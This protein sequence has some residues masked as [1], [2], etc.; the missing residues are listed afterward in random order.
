MPSGLVHVAFL[1]ARLA[2][3]LTI[4]CARA[5]S[6]S[7]PR[8][9]SL[10]FTLSPSLST[11]NI[12]ED[13][14]LYLSFSRSASTIVTPY[15]RKRFA[16]AF[17]CKEARTLMQVMHFRGLFFAQLVLREIPS[18]QLLGARCALKC[19]EVCCCVRSRGALL[20]QCPTW[21]LERTWYLVHFC[22]LEHF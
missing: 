5:L 15:R 2:R 20:H 3:L 16:A 13:P 8:P 22:V 11:S 14:P 1:Q 9:L 10:S 7:L 6:P 19:A 21:Y 18:Q 4:S 12:V 17:C